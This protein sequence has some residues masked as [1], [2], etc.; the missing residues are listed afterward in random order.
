[1]NPTRAIEER[2]RTSTSIQVR[3]LQI[4]GGNNIVVQSMTSTDTKDV[5]TTVS[6]IQRMEAAGCEMVRVAVLNMEAAAK[7]AEIKSKINI[8]LVADIHF[9]HR[10]ALE[11]VKQGVDKLRLNPG[12]ITKREKIEEVV[13]AAKDAGIPIRVGVNG[14]SLPKDLLIQYEGATPEAMVAA[15]LREIEILEDNGFSDIVIS[16]KTTDVPTMIESYRLMSNQVPY[17]LHLGVTE[18][19]TG[20]PGVIKSAIGIG[21]LLEAGIGD[22]LRVSLTGD[23]V[24]EVRAAYTM[25]NALGQRLRGVQYASCPTCGRIGINLEKIVEEVEVR[26]RDIAE[27]VKVSLI[28]CV[29]N[30]PGEAL[31][32]DIGLVGANGAGTIYVDGKP[33][34]RVPEDEL[35][36]EL[37][38]LVRERSEMMSANHAA[39]T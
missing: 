39:G 18:A 38:K 29:V 33:L 4:G 16:L 26:L 3:N 5:E 14:G 34:K 24:R 30:G 23:P 1:M 19:G 2:R 9:D 25:L 37:E 12:N 13:H 6:Q 15:G 11:A 35:V 10:L 22:T 31:H 7:L 36:D 17:P 28:G 8:P 21:T 27:P 32:S 20:D